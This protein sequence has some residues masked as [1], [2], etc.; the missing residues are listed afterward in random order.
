MKLEIGDLIR[1]TN[2]HM[3]VPVQSVDFF[4]FTFHFSSKPVKTIYPG[5]AIVTAKEH[6][7][8]DV[9]YFGGEHGGK[10]LR[11]VFNDLDVKWEK[12]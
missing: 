1:I 3:N 2:H 8:Y 7:W 9:V 5:L 11:F 12:I 10:T 6:P 4:N